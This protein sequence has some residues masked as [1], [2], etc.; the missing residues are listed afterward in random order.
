MNAKSTSDFPYSTARCVRFLVQPALQ[1]RLT[2]EGKSATLFIAAS[3]SKIKFTSG[4]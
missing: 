4:N 2:I 1:L 3:C